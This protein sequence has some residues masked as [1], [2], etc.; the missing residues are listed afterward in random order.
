MVLTIAMFAITAL[1]Y[2]LVDKIERKHK[3]VVNENYKK[4]MSAFI[5]ISFFATILV[6]L[7]LTILKGFYFDI[8]LIMV[9]TFSLLIFVDILLLFFAFLKT[10]DF[11]VTFT[12]VIFVAIST[13]FRYNLTLDAEVN[14]LYSNILIMLIGF[15]ATA[16]H[17]YLW[18]EDGAQ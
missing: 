8:K 7:F 4:V 14:V 1:F 15:A 16:I 9:I 12:H 11:A 13:F 2:R 6:M 5:T 10:S 3:D 17:Y 18:K